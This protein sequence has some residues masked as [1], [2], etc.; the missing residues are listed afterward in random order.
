MGLFFKKKETAKTK[1]Q[2][3]SVIKNASVNNDLICNKHREED[4]NTHSTLIVQPGE[5]AIFVK[6]G[7]IEQVFTNGTYDLKTENYP[8]LQRLIR[9]FSDGES[10]FNCQIFFVRVASSIEIFWGT[11]SPIQVRDRL[12]GIET[13][14]LAR[15]AY[16]IQICDSARFLTKLIGNGIS[17]FSQYD[18]K[19]YFEQE[20]LSE[21]KS[22]IAKAINGSD[23][24]I[25]GIA[26]HQKEIG[27]EV[28]EYIKDSLTEYGVGLLK[29]VVSAIDIADDNLRREFDVI[30]M[31]A[32]KKVRNAQ[33]DK[34]VM[35]ILG[36]GWQAQQLVDIQKT[37][38][39][40][41]GSGIASSAAEIGMGLATGAAFMGM[42][43]QMI[44]QQ[45]PVVSPPIS[46]W[47][48]YVN[49]QQIGPMGMAQL[50]Q[51]VSAGQFSGSDL[52]WKEGF[53]SWV[54]ANSVPELA[55]LFVVTPPTPPTPPMPPKTE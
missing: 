30:G 46:Q 34:Q 17:S 20:L 22:S 26:E 4:F 15:G 38:V 14:V 10:T 19:S 5:E 36:G 32:V 31:D 27:A 11:D 6:N 1:R 13:K 54:A 2:W 49:R 12:L 47:Y 18:I 24:E 43:K 16:K 37:L 53:P 55:S 35:D 44:G 25:L 7:V 40:N 50:Q 52:V 3:T 45:P 51:Y 23:R 8:F 48:I 33:A 21:I 41:P 42:G 39:E 9:L 28:G 29:F